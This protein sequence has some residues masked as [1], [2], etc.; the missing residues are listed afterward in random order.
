[1]KLALLLLLA[2]VDW[3]VP[4]EFR[5]AGYSREKGDRGYKLAGPGPR[6]AMTQAVDATPYRGAAVRLRATVRVEGGGSAQL[7]L[8]VDRA[9]GELGFFDDM[10]DRPI[11][12]GAWA[13]YEVIGEVAG[14]AR[15]VE[16]GVLSSGGNE[17][18]VDAVSFEKLPALSAD[19]VAARAAIER[20]YE[21]V[22]AA[23]AASDVGAIAGLAT[24]DAQVVM[25]GVRNPL[26]ALLA[27]IREQ[28]RKGATFRSRSTVTALQFAADEAKVWVNNESTVGVLGVL[29]SNRDTW[30][31]DAAGW[32]LKE[33]ALIATRPL[34]PSDVLAEIPRRAGMP[35]WKDIRLILFEG[36]RAPEI[37]GFTAVSAY[38]DRAASAAHALSYLKEHAPEEAGP[39]AL[40]FQGEDAGKLAA[41]VRA[42]DARRAVTTDWLF[43]R[44]SAVVVHQ[45]TVMRERP[46]EVSAGQAI[47][48]ASQAYPRDRLAIAIPNA[49]GAAPAVRNRYGKQVYVVGGVPK[50]LLGGAHFLDLA[51]VPRDTALGRWLAAQK[52]PHD[53][54]VGR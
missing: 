32:K 8:R 42:F 14:D 18:W 20:N 23:Y 34:T 41:V 51:S 29:S 17:V 53:A 28:M 1:M 6:G 12:S 46:D 24:T 27:Q 7:F 48:L 10:A 11:R 54:V 50:E 13:T 15:S 44:Q 52:F 40:A 4:V 22:D 33:S 9:S 21:R 19:A 36:A 38:V 26:A 39:A 31:R 37:P 35:D 47:W 5:A 25:A 43:A 16:V 3:T 45:L 30:V 2:Q 49:A